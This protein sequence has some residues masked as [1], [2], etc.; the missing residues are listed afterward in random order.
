MT[1][2]TIQ[3]M[4]RVASGIFMWTASERR[5]NR[6]GAFFITAKNYE[7][8]ATVKP[9]LEEMR[10]ATHLDHEV[11]ITCV[12]DEARE[13]G[14]IGDLFLGIQP[15]MP[16][17]GETIALGVG[18]LRAGK[19]DTG[20]MTL[21]LQPIDG[22]EELWI[23]PRKL[24]RLH[25]QTVRVF[26]RDATPADEAH[27]FDG[28]LPAVEP[29]G[30]IATSDNFQVKGIEEGATVLPK[31]KR[32]GDGMFMLGFFEGERLGVTRRKH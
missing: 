12:V 7:G 20:D 18:V 2:P 28:D 14:H 11:L 25:D 27:R 31:V 23:D 4:L 3:G 22:R 32:L 26:I 8:T 5:S 10:I 15:S 6:Y 19:A 17:V 9:A 13:S 16:K 30:A 1:T 24:Y 29:D 21:I